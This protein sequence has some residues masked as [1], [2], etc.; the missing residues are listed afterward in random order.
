MTPSGWLFEQRRKTLA[1]ALSAGFPDIPKDVLTGI[2]TDCGHRADIRGERPD[3]AAFAALSD[4]IGI[5]RRNTPAR[6][7]APIDTAPRDAKNK[8][9]FR[10]KITKIYCQMRGDMVYCPRIRA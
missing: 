2:I 7:Q 10:E 9:C 8:H 4:R 1:N 3:T 5:G 6:R